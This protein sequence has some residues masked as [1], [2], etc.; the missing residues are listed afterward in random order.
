[1]EDLIARDYASDSDGR[2]RITLIMGYF[3][4]PE[5]SYETIRKI[6][7][8]SPHFIRFCYKA[9]GIRP[10]FQITRHK[11]GFKGT[12]HT[13]WH[14][15]EAKSS[16]GQFMKDMLFEV[17]FR[18]LQQVFNS[19]PLDDTYEYIKHANTA[20]ARCRVCEIIWDNDVIVKKDL[21]DAKEFFIWFIE[22]Y[23]SVELHYELYRYCSDSE[24]ILTTIYYYNTIYA[25]KYDYVEKK[26]AYKSLNK[27]ITHVNNTNLLTQQTR[28]NLIQNIDVKYYNLDE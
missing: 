12:P 7:A 9:L 19:Y 28:D 18:M 15:F 11:Y 27:F 23:N 26:E 5:E 16:N 25:L 8:L 1:M 17:A 21:G 2:K 13:T 4:D 20:M 6:Y 3:A 24:N 14:G 10:G 22:V